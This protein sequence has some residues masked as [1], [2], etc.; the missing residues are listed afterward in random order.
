MGFRRLAAL[1]VVGAV[2]AAGCGGGTGADT[3]GPADDAGVPATN[4]AAVTETPDPANDAGAPGDGAAA[5]TEAPSTTEALP[6]REVA[7][8]LLYPEERVILAPTVVLPDD[9]EVKFSFTFETGDPRETIRSFYADAIAGIG[10][11]VLI[12]GAQGQPFAI[13][14]DYLGKALTVAFGD[15][16][17]GSVR[18]TVGVDRIALFRIRSDGN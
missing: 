13:L 10:G 6:V 15:G 3:P 2:I 1:T 17:D 4:T 18:V 5:Q 7:E 12:A 8:A 14:A 11:D 16:A 9:G